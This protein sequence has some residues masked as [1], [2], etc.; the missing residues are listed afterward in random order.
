MKKIALKEVIA[1]QQAAST[2]NYHIGREVFP[3]V[4]RFEVV[5][6]IVIISGPKYR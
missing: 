3:R 2:Q 4:K 5:R 1:D 6:Q